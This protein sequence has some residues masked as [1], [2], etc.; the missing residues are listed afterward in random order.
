M[1]N[2]K[3]KC[4]CNHCKKLRG[5]LRPED[6]PKYKDGRCI[7]ERVCKLC[8]TKI[9]YK[10]KSGYCRLCSNKHRKTYVPQI[11]HKAE[12]M[13]NACKKLRGELKV[14]D[15]PGYKDGR[16]SKQYFCKC[17]NEI[18]MNT[19]LKG[20]GQCLKC[21]T[22]LINLGRK[23]TD[24]VRGP[25][26]PH[27]TGRPDFKKMFIGTQEYKQFRKD[28]YTRDSFTCQTCKLVGGSLELHHKIPFAILLQ[29]FAKHYNQF[30]IIEDKETMIRLALNWKPFFDETNM[31]TLCSKCH[32]ETD[33]YGIRFDLMNKDKNVT[34]TINI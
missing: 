29:E 32:R 19:F 18:G 17:G 16:C 22:K 24:L 13:C 23:R 27:Y 33:S 4:K 25:T 28:M 20:K 6:M 12:C 3:H 2:H 7:E 30:S 26:N 31:I 14:E 10:S 8:P 9:T 1:I 5:E 34:S 21:S 15:L 11:T